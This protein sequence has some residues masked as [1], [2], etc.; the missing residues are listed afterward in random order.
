MSNSAKMSALERIKALVDTNSFVEIGGSITKRNTDFNLAQKEIKADGVVTGYGTIDN[1][2]VY[3][4]SQD[5][6]ALHGSIGEMHA[7]KIVSIY[8]MALKAGAPIIS[9]IDCA[10]IRIQEGIDGLAGYGQIYSAKVEAS[11]VIPQISAILGTSGGGTAISAHMSDITLMEK[12]NAKLFVNSPNAID[13][14]SIE[15]L[16]TS[17]ADFQAKAGNI[18]IVCD[19]EN[20]IFEKIKELIN[21]LPANYQDDATIDPEDDLNRQIAKTDIDLENISS[22]ISKISDNGKFIELKSEFGKEMVT[23]LGKIA[24]VT[25]G[26]VANSKEAVL[27]TAGCK[28]AEQL[29]YLCDSF[30]LPVISF[31]NVKGYA[32]SQG[33]EKTIA[34]AVAD[35]TYAFTSLDTPKINIIRGGQ[36]HVKIYRADMVLA[37]DSAKVGLMDSSA[38]AKILSSDTGDDSKDIKKSFDE[39]QDGAKAALRRGYVDN[40][41]EGE[42]LRKHLIYALQMFGMR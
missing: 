3:I 11:G 6:D 15:K 34:Q 40:L 41:I 18:D 35:M 7:R 36:Q 22:F 27:S 25:V 38:A 32:S 21:I 37:I 17:S 33:E 1:N 23:G 19:S 14:N 2:L 39:M 5:A 20:D 12:N 8:K 24:G 16:D 10:G 31:T 13:G 30:N 28:K 4:Y 26:F 9:L 29:L 42:E